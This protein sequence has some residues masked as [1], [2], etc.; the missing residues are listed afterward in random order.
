M[1]SPS[2]EDDD[3]DDEEDDDE[4]DEADEEDDE[5]CRGARRDMYA[6]F[7]FGNRAGS[8]WNW[9]P[10]RVPGG[11]TAGAAGKREEWGGSKTKDQAL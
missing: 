5:A 1:A 10:T 11:A 9:G 7:G 6:D 3:E 4:E 2:D 8:A